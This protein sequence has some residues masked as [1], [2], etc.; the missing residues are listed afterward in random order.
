MDFYDIQLLY[1]RQILEGCGTDVCRRPYCAS[2]IRGYQARNG[3]FTEAAA[4]LHASNLVALRGEKGLCNALV[5]DKPRI[6]APKSIDVPKNTLSHSML[7]TQVYKTLPCFSRKTWFHTILSLATRD[8]DVI[9]DE[10][11]VVMASPDHLLA[12]LIQEPRFGEY[13]S[14]AIQARRAVLP[15]NP[16]LFAFHARIQM[17]YALQQMGDVVFLEE[18][19][20]GWGPIIREQLRLLGEFLKDTDT[21]FA[22]KSLVASL[23]GN[24]PYIGDTCKELS[25]MPDVLVTR[26]N[27]N[28]VMSDVPSLKNIEKWVGVPDYG[29]SI[30]PFGSVVSDFDALIVPVDRG[31][32][33]HISEGRTGCSHDKSRLF[34]YRR[35]MDAYIGPENLVRRSLQIQIPVLEISTPTCFCIHIS[36]TSGEDILQQMLEYCHSQFK[37][38]YQLRLPLKI[39]FLDGEVALDL[40]GVQL[41]FFDTIGRQLVSDNSKHF[42]RDDNGIV[43]PRLNANISRSE[44]ICVGIVI[45]LALYNGCPMSFDMPIPFYRKLLDHWMGD[46]FVT[47]AEFEEQDPVAYRSL[48]SLRKMTNF[49]L[50]SASL[51]FTR[52]HVSDGVRTTYCLSDGTITADP[53]NPKMVI[54][55]EDVEEYIYSYINFHYLHPIGHFAMKMICF[56]FKMAYPPEIA[57]LMSPRELKRNVEGF[58]LTDGEDI[59]V[60]PLLQGFTYEGGYTSSSDQVVWLKEYLRQ[61]SAEKLKQFLHFTTGSERVSIGTKEGHRVVHITIQQN[62]TNATSLPSA[63][64]C[65]CILF[66]PVYPDKKTLSKYMDKGLEHSVGFGLM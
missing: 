36:R 1:E 34:C 45:G 9:Q 65:F 12:R 55:Q 40:G 44:W 56:G 57:K 61:L 29:T 58:V 54:N 24:T 3:T 23:L 15:V 27:S 20:L 50:F 22:K 17:I 11:L 10:S 48:V 42:E 51:A 31:N 60:E 38:P 28:V 62:G 59:D 2:N 35:M 43:W 39:E 53:E 5:R 8:S 46:A 32:I 18:H 16:H 30:P 66:L 6:S 49:E 41:E 21:E 64:T 47:E 25:F 4:R 19:L 14:N 33:F 63:S 37:S 52:E 13:T 7:R 26:H